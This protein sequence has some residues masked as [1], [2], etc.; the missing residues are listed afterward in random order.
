[1][2]AL[3]LAFPAVLLFCVAA[4]SGKGLPP[5]ELT[6][7]SPADGATEVPLG[8]PV[9]VRLSKPLDCATL[10]AGSIA[11]TSPA[12][13]VSGSI[14]CAGG[15]ATF[16]PA[17]PLA[18]DTAHEVAIAGHFRAI[19]GTVLPGPVRA[20]FT[21]G[22]LTV[23]S[24]SPAPGSTA[25][26]LGSAVVHLDFWAPMD[27]ATVDARN[28]TLSSAAGPVPAAIVC[29]GT[30]A[31]IVPAAPLSPGTAYAVDATASARSQAGYHLVP[32]HAE[33]TT[34]A[35]VAVDAAVTNGPVWN[36]ATS[37]DG[38]TI[39]LGGEFTAAGPRTGSFVPVSAIS[40]K[41]AGG[42][43]PQVDGSVL[44]V[45]ADG[46]GGWYL[47]G[48]FSIV[49]GTPR[50]NLAHL[51]SDGSLDPS[52]NPGANAEVSAL[53]V[54]GGAVYAGGR[55]TAVAGQPRSHLAALDPVAGSALSWA[56]EADGAVRALAVVG[57]TVYT[58]GAF[59]R[60]GGQPR[61][62]LAA[63]D[64]GTGAATSWDPGSDGEVLALAPAGTTLY[65]GGSFAT[66]GG[67]PRANLAA[68]DL[69]GGGATSWNPGADGAVW[70]LAAG[71]GA[72]YA[73]GDFGTA[74]GAPRE[75]LAAID[76]ATGAATAFRIPALAPWRFGGKGSDY[77]RLFAVSWIPP[78]ATQGA[79]HSAPGVLA[80]ALAVSGSAV[81]LGGWFDSAGGA[82]R[83]GAAAF[84]SSTGALLPWDPAADGIAG[85]F[86]SASGV[87]RA[88]L[89]ALDARTGALTA[90]DPSA[91]DP[92][93]AVLPSGP[94]VLAGG[95]FSAMGGQARRGFAILAP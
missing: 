73:A 59:Q 77:P 62:R 85:Y 2:T 89:A 84:D 93:N 31:S 36:I 56:P 9:S 57:S 46:A 55:F 10:T 41:P 48:L 34:P 86:T 64:A 71:A 49:A 23:R 61:S 26:A 88:N 79:N 87:P 53:A 50:Q 30:F 42:G 37:E 14:T 78:R 80:R 32:F 75:H 29:G 8:S 58:A 25:A 1:M 7:L 13:P 65:V 38:R 52:W 12:G 33:F 54:A 43:L 94:T 82:R 17:A 91:N 28:L 95:W 4:C 74:G 22:R 70:A 90:W 11:L 21:T 40:G 67:Q 24:M 76:A 45:A 16:T 72:V 3:R 69:T 66:A 5:L 35:A 6:Q 92:V 27:C 39:Y 63:L 44:A 19:D 15:E 60:A 68:I 47:G 18:P 83:A 20:R 81:Y 51:L